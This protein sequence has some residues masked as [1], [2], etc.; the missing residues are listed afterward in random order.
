MVCPPEE[1]APGE[2]G[3]YNSKALNLHLGLEKRQL[4]LEDPPFEF[5]ESSSSC[6]KADLNTVVCCTSVAEI[7]SV[8]HCL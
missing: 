3:G 2:G 6:S 1:G 5:K 8:V 7:S 4:L